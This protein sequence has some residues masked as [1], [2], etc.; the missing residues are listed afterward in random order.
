M[1]SVVISG[2]LKNCL[3]FLMTMKMNPAGDSMTL[4]SI[5]SIDTGSYGMRKKNMPFSQAV[6][7]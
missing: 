4:S 1:I 6:H 5:A 7:H 2:C 3:M